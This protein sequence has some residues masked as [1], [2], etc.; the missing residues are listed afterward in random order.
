MTN[1]DPTQTPATD[2]D[3]DDD[4]PAIGGWSVFWALLLGFGFV[5][6]M[7]Y[8]GI[9]DKRTPGVHSRL[10][11]FFILAGGAAIAGMALAGLACLKKPKSKPPTD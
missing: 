6:H 11:F 8:F 2:E 5:V 1:Q 9:G 3:E 4:Q 10:H 7:T